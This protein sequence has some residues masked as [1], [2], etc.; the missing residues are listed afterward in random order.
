MDVQEIAEHCCTKLDSRVLLVGTGQSALTSA[1]NL[2]RLQARFTVKVPLSDA[3]VEKV[4]RQTVLAKKP[5]R[6]RRHQKGYRRQSGRD[7]PPPAKHPAGIEPY[8][9][10]P[11]M[12]PIIR[13]Y[14]CAVVFGKRSYAT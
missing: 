3:D 11:T 6:I 7:Q 5:E 4:T 9:M 12:R 2:G 10:S 1:A 8:R 14:R 13:F